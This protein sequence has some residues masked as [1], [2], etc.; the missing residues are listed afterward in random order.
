MRSRWNGDGTE[1][2]VGCGARTGQGKQ[3]C[4]LGVEGAR[5]ERAADER[6]AITRATYREQTGQVVRG[7]RAVRHHGRGAFELRG[8][9]LAVPHAAPCHQI[10]A[11]RRLGDAEGVAAP[12]GGSPRCLRAGQALAEHDAGLQ[13]AQPS[14]RDRPVAWRHG[15]RAHGHSGLAGKIL[16]RVQHLLGR[17]GQPAER[18][19]DQREP[20]GTVQ[21]ADEVGAGQVGE[22][23]ALP[24]DRRRIQQHGS[25]AATLR[26]LL[27][28]ALV[29]VA[30]RLH[31]GAPERNVPLVRHVRDHRE[32]RVTLDQRVHGQQP[33]LFADPLE[34]RHFEV[35]VLER[36]TDLVREHP[37]RFD[38]VLAFDRRMAPHMDHVCLLVVEGDHL[39]LH[40]RLPGAA[41]P[42][43][44]WPQSER[45]VECTSIR[46]GAGYVLFAVGVQ[47]AEE[48]GLVVEDHAR[49][50][51]VGELSELGDVLDEG[52]GMTL[53]AGQRIVRGPGRLPVR[54]SAQEQHQSDA[55][56]PRRIH[57]VTAPGRDGQPLPAAPRYA[58]RDS[59][60]DWRE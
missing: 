55:L 37:A 45:Q 14:R 2:R 22:H 40:N 12:P 41:A 29:G 38:R 49:G 9:H 10:A 34:R 39:L 31:Q 4:Y 44:L 50:P 15:R 57:I 26:V 11:G 24:H 60:C 32:H 54:T 28:V 46:T 53:D 13:L 27:D 1:R 18:A 5:V 35:L 8:I 16:F 51:A 3:S 56:E 6:D 47:R 52:L 30:G 59:I 17:G 20:A 58:A 25:R 42:G 43:A 36:M 19:I 21:R 33:I 48:V 23:Q 7:G